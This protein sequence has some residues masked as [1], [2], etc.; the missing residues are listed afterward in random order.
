MIFVKRLYPHLHEMY[1][2]SGGDYNTSTIAQRYH[3][4]HE[5]KLEWEIR[6]YQK[7][8]IC[9]VEKLGGNE[10]IHKIKI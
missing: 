1:R 4:K 3:Y 5:M 7:V 10:G 8:E 6:E 9:R 2:L